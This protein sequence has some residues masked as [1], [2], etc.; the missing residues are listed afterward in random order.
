MTFGSYD[1]DQTY[2]DNLYQYFS[3]KIDLNRDFPKWYHHK[4][5]ELSDRREDLI[6]TDR[7][8]ETEVLRVL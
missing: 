1:Y 2:F 6:F 5:W 8:K 7:E 3:G 4:D